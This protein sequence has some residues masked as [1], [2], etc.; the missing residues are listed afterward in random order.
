M[1]DWLAVAVVLVAALILA[2]H[3]GR[4]ESHMVEHVDRQINH[5]K[6]F[7]MTTSQDAVNAVVAQVRKGTAEVVG[8]IAALQAQVDAGVPTEQL[9][10][11]ELS[12]AAQALDDIVPD[13]VV[14][15]APVDPVDVPVD[16][17]A[18]DA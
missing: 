6:G 11:T 2:A 7:A 15:P 18:D 4:L 16:V 8:K 13:A 3:L 14:D 12:A 10:L 5:M 1:P 9:D 17:P